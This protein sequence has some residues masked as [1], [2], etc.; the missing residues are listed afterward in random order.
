MGRIIDVLEPVKGETF[1]SWM[2]RMINLYSSEVNANKYSMISKDILNS[3][4]PPAL[5]WPEN[6]E[7][8]IAGCNLQKSTYLSSFVTVTER[9]TNINFYIDVCHGGKL[10]FDSYTQY[11]EFYK[12]HKY[13]YLQWYSDNALELVFCPECL[14]ETEEPIFYNEHQIKGNKVC[15]KHGCVLK[16]VK[17]KKQWGSLRLIYD[18]S[19]AET[20]KAFSLDKEEL[21]IA[22]QL[23][24]EVH[25]IC[26][27]G[28]KESPDTILKKISQKLFYDE[29]RIW[30]RQYSFSDCFSCFM[31]PLNDTYF[32]KLRFGFE[33][34]G[35]YE[36]LFHDKKYEFKNPMF[37]I[38][39]V[40]GIFGTFENMYE[41]ELKEVTLDLN[42]DSRLHTLN[43][44][45][46]TL[47][48][49]FF[50]EYIILGSYNELPIIK[51]RSCGCIA[52]NIYTDLNKFRCPA[53]K[54]EAEIVGAKKKVVL[55]KE[56]ISDKEFRRMHGG[57][58]SFYINYLINRN[59]LDC[60]E[61]GFH[62]KLL[63]A[64]YVFTKEIKKLLYEEWG[65]F[66]DEFEEP[67]FKNNVQK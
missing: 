45:E 66:S 16:H 32:D 9:M 8:I 63:P 1:F 27:N 21:E 57:I 28:L 41:Y 48:D 38:A 19:F 29:R 60:I 18:S 4:R 67:Y 20:A 40:C 34:R 26:E 44:Y 53:C 61:I 33:F 6:V 24:K 42:R 36:A 46:D 59:L 2:F 17:Y 11:K 3:P 55:K 47:P 52:T 37:L 23:A 25:I 51:H 62:F 7:E 15:W 65:I 56:Y 54:K 50:N 49:T 14:K 58:N 10:R 43:Y 22:T 30:E 31:E 35:L 64:N 39:C 12:E 5:F 13:N